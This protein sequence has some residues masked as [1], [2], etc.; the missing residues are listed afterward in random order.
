MSL[1]RDLIASASRP[2][3]IAPSHIGVRLADTQLEPEKNQCPLCL[4]EPSRT[5]LVKIHDAPE[6]WLLQC[7]SCRGAS[8]SRM[9]TQAFLEE[10]YR[11]YFEHPE[12]KVSFQDF[13]RFTRHMKK[14]GV[15]DRLPAAC[16]I[17]DFGGGDGRMA[18]NI[19]LRLVE[20]G[21]VQSVHIDLLDY[22]KPAASP[23]PQVTLGHAQSLGPLPDSAYDMVLASG[24][25]EHVPQLGAVLPP[26]LTKMKTGAR[27]YARVPYAAP[28][29]RLFSAYDMQFPMHVHDL[30]PDFWNH[31]CAGLLAE[32]ELAVSQPSIVKTSFAVAPMRTA[33][34]WL[35]KLPAHMQLRLPVL[36]ALPLAWRFVGGWEVVIERRPDAG[37]NTSGQNRSAAAR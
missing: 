25:F 13:A 16:R 34:A 35:L 9:P 28:M 29:K 20:E 18:L 12:V 32:A 14:L 17:L 27:L 33:A 11:N 5:P 31:A 7:P 37:R 8:A 2:V 21:A 24:I 1:L 19:A 30:G 4:A 10:Y 15:L 22:H 26:L 23:V 3:N 6:V 36:R